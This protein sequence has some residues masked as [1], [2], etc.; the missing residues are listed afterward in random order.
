MFFV[1]DHVSV[2]FTTWAEQWE[3]GFQHVNFEGML[4]NP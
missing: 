1:V 3:L 4:F 2:A